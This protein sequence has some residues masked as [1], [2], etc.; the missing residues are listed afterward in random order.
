MS[1]LFLGER[2]PELAGLEPTERRR[3]FKKAV[4][5]SYRRLP[6]WCGFF[7]FIAITAQSRTIAEAVY[8]LL[9]KSLFV[10]HRALAL[11]QLLSNI[12]ALFVLGAF[13]L[14]EVRKEIKRIRNPNK[15]SEAIRR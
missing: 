11:L 6:T 7:A 5:R 9:D 12:F 14:S 15:A 4:W 1:L 8:F 3:V 2:S 10:E 13:Q